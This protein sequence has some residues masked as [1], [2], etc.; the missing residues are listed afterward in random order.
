[1]A[2][3]PVLVNAAAG[4]LLAFNDQVS[5]SGWLLNGKIII[6][7]TTQFTGKLNNNRE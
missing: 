2:L 3:V 4:V 7:Y 1:M 5:A 6:H